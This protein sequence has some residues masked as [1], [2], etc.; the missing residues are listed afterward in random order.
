MSS[1]HMST[2]SRGPRVVGDAGRVVEPEETSCA[3][4]C[5]YGSVS[6]YCISLQ[7]VAA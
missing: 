3:Y 4:E 1:R 7:F 6:V 5:A 2:A